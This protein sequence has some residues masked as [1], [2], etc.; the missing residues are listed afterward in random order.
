MVRKLLF[1]PTK[2]VQKYKKLLMKMD[3]SLIM[4]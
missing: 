3:F 2:N 4:L 1:V